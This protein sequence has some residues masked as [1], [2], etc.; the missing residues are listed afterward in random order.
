MSVVT[1]TG[2]TGLT[3][4]FNGKRIPKCHPR[5][6]SLGELQHIG[7]V[8][9]EFISVYDKIPNI[10]YDYKDGL[11]K[12][13]NFLFDLSAYLATPR[14][15]STKEQI[16]RTEFSKDKVVTI[17]KS[18]KYFESKLPQQ[19]S[20]IVFSG[21]PP[22]FKLLIISSM[23]RKAERYIC[24]ATYDNLTERNAVMPFIN[25][26][27]DYFYVFARYINFKNNVKEISYVNENKKIK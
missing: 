2:D 11:N 27:G 9:G 8:I 20:F 13:I 7:Y 12:I 10:E 6:H 14:S 5:I 23:I 4:L 21:I 22:A 15:S 19:T 1:K 25:R 17:E 18:I 3:S 26:L 24:Q 16:E